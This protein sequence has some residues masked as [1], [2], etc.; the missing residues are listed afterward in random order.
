MLKRDAEVITMRPN[1]ILTVAV[2]I[3]AAFVAGGHGPESATAELKDPQGRT[4]GRAELSETTSGVLVR[5]A[6]VDLPAGTHAMHLHETGEC[7]GPSFESAGDHFN[8]TGD[9]H[10]FLDT[11]GAH[12]GDLPN[13]H[14]P[15]DEPLTLEVLAPEVTLAEGRASLLD[16]DGTAL[17]IHDGA[18]D[19]RTDPA[20]DAGDPIACG[21]IE[22]PAD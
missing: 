15:D 22:A 21:V 12:A 19:Y 10:G 13:V 9:D 16:R 5:L 7:A 3:P 2:L 4:I 8:P 14:V 11:A 17:V 20:G 6:E 18:D 1:G